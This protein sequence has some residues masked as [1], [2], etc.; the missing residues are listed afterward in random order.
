MSLAIR[1]FMAQ[2]LYR[3][4]PLT[5]EEREEFEV[6]L[7]AFCDRELDRLGEI[8]GL[9]VLYAGGASPLWLEGLSQ[10]IGA[11]GSLTAL[12]ADGERLAVARASL[13][14]MDLDAPVQFVQGDVFEPPFGADAFDLVYS[15]GLFHELDV[16]ER[17][18]EDALAALVGVVRPGG[19]VA[20]SDFVD[21]TAAAQIEDEELSRELAR[22][23]SGAILYGI[24]PPERLVALHERVLS[25]VR[26]ISSPPF[27][28]RHL[29][30]IVLSEKDH[31]EGLRI[32]HQ[33][34]RELRRRR[35]DSREQVRREGY[36]RPTTIY[37][38]GIVPGG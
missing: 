7:I 35:E 15:A 37:V 1:T 32:P 24:G 13:R 2:R 11:E 21:S 4:D 27:A 10:R 22:A 14:E 3:E 16:R 31:S 6:D 20:T 26:S 30:K 19:R 8:E 5:P 23:S 25:G 38:E 17:P 36:T 18:A 33:A 29:D 9:R 34:R 28:I 12:E